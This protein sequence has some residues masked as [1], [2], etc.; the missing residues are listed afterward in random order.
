MR[1]QEIKESDT[2]NAEGEET[3]TIKTTFWQR[4]GA[5]F[6]DLWNFI[7]GLFGGKND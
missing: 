1:T 4:V 6:V 5:M 2:K 3:E 7:K